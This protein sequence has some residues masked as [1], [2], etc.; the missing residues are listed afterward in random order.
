[1]DEQKRNFYKQIL[2]T[3]LAVFLLGVGLCFVSILGCAEVKEYENIDAIF[4]Q[5]RINY[6]MA[7]PNSYLYINF[8]YDSDGWY[9]QFFPEGIKTK[10]KIIIE[11]IDTRGIFPFKRGAD[12]YKLQNH[13]RVI[14]SF[15]SILTIDMNTDIVA[16]FYD[17]RNRLKAYFYEG[18]YFLW[19]SWTGEYI[20]ILEEI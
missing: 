8:Y 4:E 5:A 6:M 1:M 12:R 20:F 18:K 14:Y 19:N 7:N 13:L 2:K 11:I 3:L 17:R 9:E 15:I 16:G 10:S